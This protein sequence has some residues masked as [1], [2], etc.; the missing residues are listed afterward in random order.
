MPALVSGHGARLR[1]SIR[2]AGGA[3]PRWEAF[4][5]K[6][7]P[8]MS[9][10]LLFV[11]A[12]AMALLGGAFVAVLARQGR[13]RD[14]VAWTGLAL[15]LGL[16]VVAGLLVWIGR[17]PLAPP[18]GTA[19]APPAAFDTT[20][21]LTER[22]MDAP[23]PDFAFTL[24]DGTTEKLSN[25][26]GRVVLLNFWATWCV[27][28]LQEL[29]AL[30]RL[31]AAYGPL[32]LTVVTLSDEAPDVVRAFNERTPLATTNGTVDPRGPLPDPYRRTLSVRPTTYII[33]R[34]GVIRSF[35]VGASTYEAFEVLLSD[36]LQPNVAAR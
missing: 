17:Q 31:Q 14:A 28:C 1:G 3:R 21:R 19:G 2:P 23:A 5:P 8:L 18:P 27:P 11:V 22:E 25:L 7:L 20:P 26:R 16:F 36:Y 4:G 30:N 33:D 6:P 35:G 12:G 15:S 29:P 34:A 32:G 24:L 9:P 10:T 13:P